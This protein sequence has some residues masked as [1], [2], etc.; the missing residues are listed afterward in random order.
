MSSD[1]PTTPT[2]L[3]VIT[4]SGVSADDVVPDGDERT[5]GSGDAGVLVRDAGVVVAL[6]RH[7]PGHTRPAH[8]VDHAAS[9]A[10][11]AALG[12]DRVLAVASTGSLRADWPV[13]TVVMPD[14]FFAPW[15]TPSRY[16]DA[17]GHS[18]PGFDPEWRAHVRDVWRDICS[19]PV[20]DGGVYVQTTGPRF[21]TPAEVRFLATVG[22]VVGMTVASECILAKEF[23]LSY[24]VVCM[25][26]NIANGLADA[27]LTIDE[28]QAGVASNREQLVSDLR[29]VVRRISSEA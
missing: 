3:A 4:G 2:R 7:G 6:G 27:T 15:A 9:L 28:F 29:R 14:D 1:V 21:E 10:A 8:R 12:C 11:V 24:A 19:T 18:V 26:D 16:D 5:I 17:R 25:V 23:D 22:D 20:I 13:G